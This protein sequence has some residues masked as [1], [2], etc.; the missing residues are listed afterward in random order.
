MEV[1]MY[2]MFVAYQSFVILTKVGKI[3]N[4][5][6]INTEKII[7]FIWF[8]MLLVDEIIQVPMNLN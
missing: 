7:L 3:G 6:T 5:C 8:G 1:A 4:K 2:V